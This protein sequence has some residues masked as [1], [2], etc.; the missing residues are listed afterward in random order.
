MGRIVVVTSGKGGVGK[1]TVAANMA[2]MI[3]ASGKSVCVVDADIGLN[4]L[5]VV[6]GVEN[7]IVYDL[8][9]CMEGR[10]RVFQSIL[11]DDHLPGL[12][13]LPCCKIYD[14]RNVGMGK[15]ASVIDV[16]KNS[17]DFI[18]ID[19]PAG[20]G[21]GFLT[22]TLPAEEAIVVLNPQI[23]SI[24]DAYKVIGI[25]DGQQKS[26][27]SVV[28]NRLNPQLVKKK[29]MLSVEEI[30]ML[31]GKKIVGTIPESAELGFFNS[32]LTKIG[33]F[34]DLRVQY[35]FAGLCKNIIHNKDD[36]Y[37]LRGGGKLYKIIGGN[38]FFKKRFR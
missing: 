24:R 3:A 33:P 32:F 11:K 31:I 22:A 30:E 15:F 10:C 16:L 9:D 13:V 38:R 29:K 37:E 26:N 14:A 28:V 35:A 23:S 25:L 36:K 18:I 19:C 8:V 21:D 27:V 6:L 12:N 17:F 2:I 7:R 20:I 34:E 1:T 4:N 5:D